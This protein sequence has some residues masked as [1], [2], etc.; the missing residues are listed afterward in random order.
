MPHA[1]N[2]S[3]EVNGYEPVTFDE[4]VANNIAFKEAHGT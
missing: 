1:L 4:L 3:V 2:A